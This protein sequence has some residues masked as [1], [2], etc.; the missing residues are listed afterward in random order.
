M[1]MHLELKYGSKGCFHQNFLLSRILF[2]GLSL[3]Q[4]EQYQLLDGTSLQEMTTD[5]MP[6]IET[7]LDNM[8]SR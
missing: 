7:R 3:D 1:D 6:H 2:L 4:L 8:Y 5:L